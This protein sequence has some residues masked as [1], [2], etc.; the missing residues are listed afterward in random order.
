VPTDPLAAFLIGQ[1]TQDG[2]DVVT[3]LRVTQGRLPVPGSAQAL[4]VA[5]GRLY[6]A[7]AGLFGQPTLADISLD[8]VTGVDVR[9]AKRLTGT[10]RELSVWTGDATLRFTVVDD[11]TAVERFLR[12]VRAGQAGTSAG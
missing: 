2:H 8:T 6:L 12:A 11:D 10:R 4:G 5:G 1:L 9:V 3:V 7:H